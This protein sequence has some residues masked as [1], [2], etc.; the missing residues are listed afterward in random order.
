[1]E[2]ELRLVVVVIFGPLYYYTYA[3]S[4][5]LLSQLPY[6]RGRAAQVTI[7]TGAGGY[8]YRGYT[9]AQITR[10]GGVGGE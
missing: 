3:L 7:L 9:D 1:M 4:T 8:H 2:R 6:R 5:S 10:G